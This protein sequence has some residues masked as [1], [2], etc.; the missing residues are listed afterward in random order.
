MK[1]A[2]L[3]G[4]VA[5]VAGCGGNTKFSG[6]TVALSITPDP[7]VSATI[8]QLT[9]SVSGADTGSFAMPP[10]AAFAT[11]QAQTLA[12]DAVAR[13]GMLDFTVAAMAHG[14]PVA[15]GTGSVAIKSGGA[16]SLSIALAAVEGD[17]MTME[18]DDM[19][20]PLDMAMP[21]GDMTGIV[22]YDLLGLDLAHGPIVPSNT[23]VAY[24]PNA[25][26]LSGVVGINT[27][28][29]Q[30]AIAAGPGNDGG[31]L[32][33]PPTG[34]GFVVSGAFAVLTVGKWTVDKEVA[35]T[36]TRGLIVIAKSVD[37]MNVIHAE[38]VGVTPGPGG[39]GPALGT[40]HGNNG[41]TGVFTIP[42]GGSI[43]TGAGGG[44]ASHASAGGVGGSAFNAGSGAP[45]RSTA[46]PSPT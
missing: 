24:D 29:L 26:D 25:A 9:V 16:A 8:E 10:S 22:M 14:L 32:A 4:L 11:G 13:S 34:V 42:F 46:R 36:G 3:V 40:G 44:G 1:R 2:I 33:A 15:M 45:A 23:T 19:A 31:V 38:A 21:P 30:I 18:L 12:Y 5:A 39:A 41:G 7:S 27:T 35:I 43:P 17:D 37:V 20:A 28:T 6:S